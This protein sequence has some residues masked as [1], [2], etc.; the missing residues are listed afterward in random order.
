[1]EVEQFARMRLIETEEGQGE[2]QCR[3][4]LLMPTQAIAAGERATV[5]VA[6]VVEW[7]VQ[8]E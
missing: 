1:M 2:V 7:E 8:H 3:P 5:V 6:A 4:G